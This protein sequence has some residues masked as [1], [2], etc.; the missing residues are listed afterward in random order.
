[1]EVELGGAVSFGY[2]LRIDVE[3][4][5]AGFIKASLTIGFRYFV[6]ILEK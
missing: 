2:Y 6:E 3:D 1:M 4:E 5:Y